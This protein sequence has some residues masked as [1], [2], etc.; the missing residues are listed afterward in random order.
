MSPADQL[1]KLF[2]LYEAE[3]D[4]V[5]ETLSPNDAMWDGG[6]AHYRGV[7]ESAVRCIKLALLAARKPPDSIRTILD[8]PSGHGRVLRYLL[9][10]F[11]DAAFTACDTDRD[12]VDFCAQTFG[13]H[14]V[15][16]NPELSGLQFPSTY[17][18]IWCGSLVTHL[19][20]PRWADVISLFDSILSP[21]G[22]L[23]FTTAGPTIPR[24]IGRG[25]DYFLSTD[26]LRRLLAAYRR[27]GFGY[28]DYEGQESYGISIARPAWTLALL[29]DF[30]DLNLLAYLDAGWD[31]HQDVVICSKGRP[32]L[33]A[34]PCLDKTAE[35]DVEGL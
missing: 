22:L 25:W 14:P 9:P 23:V 21:G 6:E 19:D 8:L 4:S 27:T 7:G 20:G 13:A 32:E 2:A 35:L 28:V 18:L 16:S 1:G 33:S 3:V 30:P 11:P 31:R 5:D 17:E 29:Q 34:G 24:L 12:G 26:Q 15:Y 10:V